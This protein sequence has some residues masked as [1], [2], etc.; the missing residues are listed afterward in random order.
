VDP[1]DLPPEARKHTPEGAAAFARHYWDQVN[2]AWTGPDTTLIPPLSEDGCLSCKAMQDVALELK[3]TG[4]RYERTPGEVTKVG[5]LDGAPD[6][7]QRLRV[8]VR[9]FKT[10][11]VDGSGV[12]VSTDQAQQF[13]RTMDL[14]WQGETWLVYGIA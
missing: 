4:Q 8:Q 5:P 10:N 7:R 2:K 14:V 9:Q 1:A 6:G 11:V 3:Q 13:G 12:V